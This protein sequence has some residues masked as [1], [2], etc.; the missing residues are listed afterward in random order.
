MKAIWHGGF[1]Y[2]MLEEGDRTE[3]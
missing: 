2:T 3:A 1:I